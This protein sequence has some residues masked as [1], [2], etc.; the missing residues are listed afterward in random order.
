MNPIQTRLLDYQAEG[1]R[2]LRTAAGLLRAGGLVAF[3]TETVYGLGALGLNPHSVRRIFEAKERPE[4]DPL[5]LHVALPEWARLLAGEIPHA[6]ERLAAAFWP[7]PLT[8][9]LPKNRDVPDLVTAGLD[10]VAVRMPSHPVALRLLREVGEPLAAPSANLFG[11]TSPTTA[12]HVLADLN[13]RINAVLDAGPTDVGVESTVVDVRGD[14]PVLLRPGGISREELERVLG[15]PVEL[16]RGGEVELRSPGLLA[17]H[18]S[19]RAEL[20]LFAG[21]DDSAV[22][23]AIQRDLA[24]E[25]SPDQAVLAYQEDVPVFQSLPVRVIEL[26]SRTEPERV[27]QRLYAALREADEAGARLLYARLLPPGGLAEAVNDRLLRAASGVLR[28]V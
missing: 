11:H 17:R 9:V 7:G 3:P 18:Y 23:A 6:F 2:A 4:A 22:L 25:A 5:I 14:T 28:T 15:R 10:S 13:G 21:D 16:H 26:P 12:A 20:R 8:L 19:P 24:G 1:D 27:A